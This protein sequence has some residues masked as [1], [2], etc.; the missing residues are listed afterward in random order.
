MKKI[1]LSTALALLIL[2]AGNASALVYQPVDFSSDFTGR[3]QQAGANYINEST[4]TLAGTVDL[5]GI[6][7]YI[8]GSPEYNYWHSY[9]ASG[10]S[11]KTLDIDVGLY[12]V[13][14][15]HTLINT[16]WGQYNQNLASI[17]FFGSDGAYYKYLLIGGVDIRDYCNGGYTNEI[18]SPNT[19]QIWNYETKSRLDKQVFYLPSEFLTQELA[20]ITLSDYGA[21]NS[22][23]IFLTGVTAGYDD[24]STVPIPGAAWLLGSG[25]VGLVGL[26]R[27][28]KS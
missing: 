10:T 27:K 4:L 24:P 7:F 13:S 21:T 23:R 20:S 12:G 15:V 8:P 14:E 25:L 9:Y 17:E 1:F 6:P 11:S 3:L 22:Q 28:K 26:R 2:A 16:Y 5:G 18:T 19:T